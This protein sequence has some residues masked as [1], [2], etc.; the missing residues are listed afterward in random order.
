M[1]SDL[2]SAGRDES[3]RT[4]Q[5]GPSER[6][7]GREGSGRF[8]ETGLFLEIAGLLNPGVA[9]GEIRRNRQ[10]RDTSASSSAVISASCR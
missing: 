8:A 5:G 2:H 9:F 7:G 6:S 4:R 3:Y 10:F 1:V